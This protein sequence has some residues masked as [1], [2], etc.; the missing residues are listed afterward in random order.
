MQTARDVRIARAAAADAEALLAIKKR[1]FAEEFA[2]YG[3]TPPEFD[4]VPRQRQAIV[5]RMYYGIL[6]DGVLRGGLCLLKGEGGGPY[7][8]T[9]I[10]VDRGLQD[11]G[12]GQRALRLAEELI[13]PGSVIE[14]ETPYMSFRNHHFYER[15]GYTKVGESRPDYDQTGRFVLFVYRKTVGSDIAGQ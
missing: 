15:L 10:Y 12:I 5:E 3:V 9:S 4:S 11:R 7:R 13:P 14:L 8:L 2:F 6:C 1:A